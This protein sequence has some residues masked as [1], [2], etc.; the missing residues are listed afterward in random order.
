[1]WPFYTGRTQIERERATVVST[2]RERVRRRAG[3]S[4]ARVVLAH[5]QF[6]SSLGFCCTV[7]T[8]IFAQQ[9]GW[10]LDVAVVEEAP[11]DQLTCVGG[12]GFGPSNK[13]T[14][15]F[16]RKARTHRHTTQ[17]FD[18]RRRG[19]LTHG[20]LD[21][22]TTPEKKHTTDRES[23]TH[24]SHTLPRLM[25][26]CARWRKRSAK[27]KLIQNARWTGDKT[28]HDRLQPSR[29]CG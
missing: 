1:M 4:T 10:R 26:G 17:R 20:L 6:G 29:C 25:V 8:H 11:G 9:L 3:G 7:H 2:P 24:H 22:P 28:Q 23:R 16:F 12:S 14:L 15:R 5:S 19:K 18:L 27:K 13:H 21:T